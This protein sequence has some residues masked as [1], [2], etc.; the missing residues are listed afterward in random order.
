MISFARKSR[1]AQI[2]IGCVLFL[3]PLCYSRLYGVLTGERMVLRSEHGKILV[4]TQG[5]TNVIQAEWVGRIEPRRWLPAPLITIEFKWHKRTSYCQ[6]G[7][8]IGGGVHHRLQ[9]FLNDAKGGM[10][11]ELAVRPYPGVMN[12]CSVLGIALMALGLASRYVEAIT[13]RCR[14]SSRK[15]R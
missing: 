15:R 11:Q 4:S 1:I 9:R 8:P 10:T 12:P 6:G 5:N 3:A 13:A 2:L 7:W 14:G